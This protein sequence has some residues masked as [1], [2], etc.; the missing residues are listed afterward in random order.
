M[1]VDSQVRQRLNR[2]AS[3]MSAVYS[4][5]VEVLNGARYPEEVML[6]R[7]ES[8]NYSRVDLHP[9]APGEFSL[10][11]GVFEIITRDYITAQ[12]YKA[13]SQHV[14]YNSET[15]Q[16]LEKGSRGE[17]FTLE[18]VVLAPL[19]GGEIRASQYRNIREFPEAVKNA[20]L[21]IEDRRFYSHFGIDIV[22]IARAMA[23]NLRAGRLIQGGSTLTQ[24]L[25]KNMFFSP[26]RSIGRKL[27]EMFAAVS[28]ELR[29]TKDEILDMY[30]NEIYFSQDGAVSIHGVPEAARNFFG[31]DVTDLTVSEA[32]LL[33]G[34]VRGP[35]AYSPR[36]YYKRAMERRDVV[37]GEMLEQEK[38]TEEEYK[39][40]KAEKIEIVDSSSHKRTAPYLV[41]ELQRELSSSFNVEA[42]AMSGMAVHTGLDPDLQR[43]AENAVKKNLERLKKEFPALNRKK[44]KMEQSLVA[45]EPH[46]G[47]VKAWVGGHDFSEN[48]FDHVEQ[49][50]R[51][52]GSTIKPFLYLTALDKSL[53][54]Y[55][56]ATPLSILSDEPTGITLFQNTTWQPEN[57]DHKFRGDV[58]L[59]YALEHSLNI[60]AVYVAQRVG[61]PT[62]AQTLKAFRV[63]DDVPIV[64]ALA[65]GALET[66][67]LKL[68]AAYGALA[69][70]GLYIAPRAYTTAMD[71]DGTTL[72]QS[73]SHEERVADENAT[74]LVT[75][76][77]RGVVERGTATSVRRAGFTRP[78]AGKTG[79][80]NDNRDSW[81]VGYVPNLVAGV[82]SGF[83]DNSKTGLTG[84]NGSAPTWATFM[85]CA[86]DYIPEMEFIPPPGVVSVAI[87]KQTLRLATDTCP[88]DRSRVVHEIFVKGTEPV[89]ECYEEEY[90]QPKAP[91]DEYPMDEYEE[92]PLQ[93]PP[94]QREEGGFWSQIFG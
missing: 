23:Q 6:R 72:A 88:S 5:P 39:K 11:D 85:K 70:G 24:Q 31:K 48:Q 41:A 16:I 22:G 10:K 32:A 1:K 51:Q 46:S 7:L 94:V 28:L 49:A 43:C 71:G 38:I 12:G 18:P 13:P 36:R 57:F 3:R 59:R 34:M 50:R 77:L 81:F 54:N 73:P 78:A 19:G 45:I 55:K 2:S 37:L 58:T 27:P 56:V 61:I 4:S 82:W 64:P 30:L 47:L 76:I 52:I 44:S 35:S 21:A 90:L 63:S 9:A 86:M 14:R 25:A 68:T 20:F 26:K 79:T 65:L 29:L 62:L 93:A 53:N 80:S 83:D 89:E 87:D 8:R 33:A 69:N 40:A 42:A 92:P 74:Y 60:P 66:N 67:L 15:G 17:S 75:D 91:G 84:G